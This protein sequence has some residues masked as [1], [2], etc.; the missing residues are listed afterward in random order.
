MDLAERR[1]LIAHNHPHISVRR[2]AE[3]LNLNRSGIYY[4][5]RP[6]RTD[7]RRIRDLIDEVYTECPFY[8]SR[9]LALEV[10]ERIGRS[11]NRKPM[12]RLMREM[13]I[14]ALVPSPSTS[15][16]HPGHEVYPYLLRDREIT[17]PN[18]VWSTD[19][20]Y[21]RLAKGFAFLTAVIDWYSR[22]VLSWKLSNTL[23]VDGP[24]C[25]LNGALGKGKPEIFNTD[26]GSQFT[27]KVF[28]SVLKKSE[29][30][31]SMDGRGRALDNVFIERLWRSVKYED[32]YPR[33]YETMK[34]ANE[35]LERYF[36]F[37][38]N[39]RPHQALRYKR[40]IEVHN[41]VQ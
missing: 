12:Q 6:M 14:A 24:L 22:Y 29:I 38:N 40:P 11:V 32:I 30:K 7:E 33:G 2:Q 28:T 20:T 39:R 26:Q 4:H 36:D 1:E 34:E 18:E 16:S 10:G 21:V 13:G 17:R 23:D 8:G 5:P 19:I 41:I 27:S 35:G 37:Y 31:I 15:Q 3:L 9:K 25:A